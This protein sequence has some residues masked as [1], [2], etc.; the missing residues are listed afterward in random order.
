MNFLIQ[1]IDFRK[2]VS[3]DER[4]PASDK[5]ILLVLLALIASPI[6]VIP[7]WIPLLGQLDDLVMISIILD[8]FYNHLDQRILLSHYPWGMKSFIRLKK[9][10][11]WI[12]LLSPKWFKR[13]IWSY[14][15][16]LY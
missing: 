4:I 13:R 12:T 10:T 1:L 7:D 9:L 15:P 2:N 6:D 8:Y 14:R 3:N 16:E 11:A 5:K